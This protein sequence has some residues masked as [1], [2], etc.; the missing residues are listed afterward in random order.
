MNK[1]IRL[2]RDKEGGSDTRKY[3]SASGGVLGKMC[4]HSEIRRMLDRSIRERVSA[5]PVKNMKTIDGRDYRLQTG[6]GG[7]EAFSVPHLL[8]PRSL[9]A[10]SYPN[11]TV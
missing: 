9:A 4:H 11:I 3:S 6:R 10:L 7:T 5:L 2:N 8:L 1:N